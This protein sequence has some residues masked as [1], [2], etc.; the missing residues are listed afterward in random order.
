MLAERGARP[1]QKTPDDQGGIRTTVTLTPLSALE[2]AV[3]AESA[4]AS[5]TG[6]LF[7]SVRTIGVAFKP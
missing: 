4:A 6:R 3:V 2:A 5:G 1:E 7:D